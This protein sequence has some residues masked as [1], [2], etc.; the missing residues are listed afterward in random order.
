[1]R[2][3]SIKY[4]V[5]SHPGIRLN[6]SKRLNNDVPQETQNTRQTVIRNTRNTDTHA[7]MPKIKQKDYRWRFKSIGRSRLSLS[8]S[9]LDVAV[10]DSGCMICILSI[11]SSA[12]EAVTKICL[13]DSVVMF[14]STA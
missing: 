2:F 4:S 5:S 12:V 10:S 3:E 7:Y 14:S 1:M 13:S 8:H 11:N 6:E 9:S